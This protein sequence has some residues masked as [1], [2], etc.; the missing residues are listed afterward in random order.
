MAYHQGV[1]ERPPP[2]PAASQAGQSASLLSLLQQMGG[3]GGKA[4]SVGTEQVEQQMGETSAAQ[5]KGK[6]NGAA[7]AQD[8]LKALMGGSAP[9]KEAKV[10]PQVEQRE[11]DALAAKGEGLASSNG[12]A[13]VAAP[14]P[15]PPQFAPFVSTFDLLA[16]AHAK[17]KAEEDAAAGQVQLQQT[18]TGH[19]SRAPSALPSHLAAASAAIK[20]TAS[21]DSGDKATRSNSA[22]AV[23][24]DTPSSST[25]P[26]HLL[27]SQHLSSANSTAGLQ[28]PTSQ[29]SSPQTLTIDL[30]LPQH[31]SLSP[32]PAQLQ[33]VTLF[34]VPPSW[35]TNSS[36]SRRVGIWSRGLVY[37]TPSG[38]GTGKGK[39]RIRVIEREKGGRVLL[40]GG[41]AGEVEGVEVARGGEG[42]WRMV[43]SSGGEGRVCL[44]SVRED[45]GVGEGEM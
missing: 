26:R 37:A 42:G 9:K 13:E 31:D 17:E 25:P 30:S 32:T 20:S 16:Q 23:S 38:K 18:T 7:A 2:P 22:P 45:G 43:A 33:P 24:L 21:S 11:E 36:P 6:E 27:A 14:A 39:G 15:T 10:A 44:W 35:C 28:L 3:S 1:I 34:S 41:H 4:P 8:L 5:T 12:D 29:L 19:P 40:K